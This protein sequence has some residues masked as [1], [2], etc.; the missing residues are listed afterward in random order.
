MALISGALTNDWL[1]LHSGSP[2]RIQVDDL[3]ANRALLPARSGC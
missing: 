1:S 2:D 3:L